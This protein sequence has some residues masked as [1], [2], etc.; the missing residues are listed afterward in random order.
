MEGMERVP[1]SDQQAVIDDLDRNIILF[2]SAGT[3]KT[4]TVARRV[5]A[6][7]AS[8]RA[9]PSEIL[10]LTFTIRAA[11]EMKDDITEYAGEDARDVTV[12]TI[13]SFAYQLLKEEYVRKPEFYSLP[14]VCDEAESFEIA[15]RVLTEMGLEEEN[16]ALKN[17][18]MITGFLSFMKQ[19]RELQG[20]YG[21]DEAEDFRQVYLTA[22][23]KYP[24]RL[25]KLISK[26]DYRQQKE[27]ADGDFANLLEHHAG[28]FLHRYCREL[29]QSNLLD[30]DDLICQSRRLLQ[31]AEAQAYWQQKYRYI[32]VDEM[33]DTSELE[34]DMLS[35]LFP[36]SRI[37]MCGDFFQTIYQW[38]GSNPEK[39]LGKYVRDMN[40]VQ[41]MFSRNYRSTQILTRA[42]FGY[43][44]NTWPELMGRFCPPD[45]RIESSTPGEPIQHWQTNN[46]E[47]TA[48]WIYRYFLRYR[49]ADPSKVCIMC[50]SNGGIGEL[51]DRLTEIGKAQTNEADRLRFFTVEKGV[52]LFRKPVI[53]DLLAF[54]RV[55]VNKTDSEAVRR[56][57]ERYVSGVGKETIQK[58]Q[59]HGDL[60]ISLVSC[61]DP[62]LYR[63]GDPYAVLI[64][65]YRQ[66]QVV[67]YDTETTGLDLDKDQAFQISAIRLG[68]DGE[69]LDTLDQLMIPTRKI[70]A[71]AQA[72]HHQTIETIRARGAVSMREG[73]QNFLRFCKGSMLVGHNNLAFD[74]PL[75]RRM[76]NELGLPQP[77]ILGEF[78]TLILAHQL[79][80]KS[81]NHK[82]GTLCEHFGIV[83]EAAHDALGDITAT[84]KLLS[85]FLSDRII[86]QTAARTLALSSFRPKFEKLF[87]FIQNLRTEYLEK[88]DI[89]GLAHK[90]AEIC[91]I[92]SDNKTESAVFALDDFLFTIDHTEPGDGVTLLRS[93][94]RDSA[95]SGSQIDLL[96]DKLKKIPII[97]VH[98][99][100]GC[101]FD[102]VIIADADDRNYPTYAAQREQTIEEEK[103]V[104]YVAISRAKQKLILVSSRWVKTRYVTWCENLPSRFIRNIPRECIRSF[105]AR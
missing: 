34:Y 104:F 24:A 93:M 45:V 99:S 39:V 61:L 26:Y 67:V 90:A 87:A 10:C 84:G 4:F 43:L 72:T 9:L 49:P 14:T 20:R 32:T 102:T 60:G 82:L 100:K 44:Q 105:Q 6:V 88:N 96:L 58:I 79:M 48:E 55:L 69:I 98:Q 38:R 66:G 80:P 18:Q 1:N 53:R 75:V 95:L 103:R 71:A 50:R 37:M 52:K 57:T 81:V 19:Q 54:F 27:V 62:D 51:Y 76:L 92:R 89:S 28:A 23:Q 46:R 78:D 85:R 74:S 12:K 91:R 97:T 40:A 17:A 13:H 73:M 86:P 8:G 21:E 101:E 59:E 29:R 30:F 15:S 70:C 65:A 2:A 31:D 68:P 16:P 22:R 33:Q 64:D 11:N 56:L 41:Y 36:G 3:G 42:S 47:Q 7:I 63:H 77:E 35:R 83:N 94:I 5:Q 25:Q